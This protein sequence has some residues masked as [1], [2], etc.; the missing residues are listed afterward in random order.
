[1]SHAIEP[2]RPGA[3]DLTHKLTVEKLGSTA[4]I[5]INHPPANTWDRDALI[6]LRQVIQ[7]LNA[8]DD[9]LALI[10]TGQGV[11]YFSAGLE[12]NMLAEADRSFA[13]EIAARTGEAFTALREFRGVSI[14]A[15][16]GDALGSGLE[17]ALACDIRIAERHA[18]LGLP[19][20]PIGLLPCGGG[21]Q[22][23]AR[24]TGEGWSKRLL[25]LGERIDAQTAERIGLIEQLVEPGESRGRALLMASRISSQ[26]PMAMRTLKPLIHSAPRVDV[27]EQGAIEREAFVRL[28]DSGQAQAGI[29]NLLAQQAADGPRN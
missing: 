3:F 21:A 28:F 8:D 18:Q 22:A 14:A 25:L 13:W 29:R 6:G 26:S 23:L 4:L 12:L 17:C 10:L 27:H 15:I 11:R 2:Y 19:E 24:L 9:I 7:H 20:A 1:M 16:N 5:T